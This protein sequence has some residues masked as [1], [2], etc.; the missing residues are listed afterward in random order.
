M[1]GTFTVRIDLGNDAMRSRHDI[2]V[3]LKSI[4]IKVV[5]G[6]N[7]GVV[8]DENGNSVGE[9]KIREE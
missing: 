4:A 9:F 6:A 1:N 2:F 7:N 8:M 5:G 3:A